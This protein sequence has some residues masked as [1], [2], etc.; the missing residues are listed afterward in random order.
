MNRRSLLKIF[1]GALAST[2]SGAG[3]VSKTAASLLGEAATTAVAQAPTLMPAV[4]AV[5]TEKYRNKWYVSEPIVSQVTSKVLKIRGLPKAGLGEFCDD[6]PIAYEHLDLIGKPSAEAAPAILAELSGEDRITYIRSLMMHVFSPQVYTSHHVDRYS[7]VLEILAKEMP[8]TYRKMRRLEKLSNLLQR[9]SRLRLPSLNGPVPPHIQKML[10][11]YSNSVFD[12]RNPSNIDKAVEFTRNQVRARLQ[13][14]AALSSY[15]NA[16]IRKLKSIQARI[17]RAF[18]TASSRDISSRNWREQEES[19][20]TNRSIRQRLRWTQRTRDVRWK[21]SSKSYESIWRIRQVVV[22]SLS[23]HLANFPKTD[24]PCSNVGAETCLRIIK[25]LDAQLS[26]HSA[27]MTRIPTIEWDDLTLDH[28]QTIF[29]AL[30]NGG[31]RLYRNVPQDGIV[32]EAL[33]KLGLGKFI[34]WA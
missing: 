8:E 19:R 33:N 4:F 3:A 10:G 28:A 21:S 22:D 6:G 12:L 27:A 32:A 29:R 30:I 13:Y 11:S 5:L 18:Y 17:E 24:G 15:A 26:V 34:W 16:P 7:A 2:T 20:R 23:E 14:N 1:G 25:R 31:H 9:L